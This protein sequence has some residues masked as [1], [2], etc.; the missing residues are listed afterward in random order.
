[1]RQEGRQSVSSKISEVPRTLNGYEGLEEQADDLELGI[2]I[3]QTSITDEPTSG[4]IAL[5]WKTSL[6]VQDLD[7]PMYGIGCR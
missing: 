4:Y 3:T 5:F 7:K 2:P 6:I 1:M